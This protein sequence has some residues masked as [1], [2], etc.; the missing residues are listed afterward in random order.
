MANNCFFEMT[1]TFSD[2]DDAK[3]C[4]NLLMQRKI[5]ADKRGEGFR[6]GPKEQYLF[7]TDITKT[8]PNELYLEG[9]VRWGFDN[10]AFAWFFQQA[11]EN[12]WSI[13]ECVCKYHE[14]MNLFYGELHYDGSLQ[15]LTDQH[16]KSS[17]MDTFYEAASEE[18]QESDDWFDKLIRVAFKAPDEYWELEVEYQFE[19]LTRKVPNEEAQVLS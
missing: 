2:Q 18:E 4:Y 6:F 9:W 1:I 8:A 12:G 10:D 3:T 7:D 5:V 15:V 16:V 19:P 11:L 13:T 17:Y 14:P